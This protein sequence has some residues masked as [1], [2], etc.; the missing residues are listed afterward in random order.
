LLSV[1]GLLQ[2]PSKGDIYFAG[3]KA[4]FSSEDYMRNYI[5]KNISYVFQEFNLIDDFSVV[6]NLLLVCD[7]VELVNEILSTI[8]LLNKKSTPTKLLSG[9][10][11]QRLAIGR[12]IAKSGNIILLD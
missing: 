11:K 4:D 7:N 3:K 12:A 2:T 9:G 8:G 1:I 5:N 6:D 10:E